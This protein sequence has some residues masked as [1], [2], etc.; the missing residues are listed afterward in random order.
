MSRGALPA[1]A[2]VVVVGGGVMGTSAA[3][4]LAEAGAEVVLLERDALASG[5]TS[6][7][8]GGVR[9]QFSDPLNIA[10]ALRSIDSFE[11]FAER[12]GAE[13]DLKQV[14]YLFLLDRAEDVAAFEAAVALQNELGVPSRMVSA[15]EAGALSPLAGIEGVLAATFC[16][17]DGHASPEAVVS[18]YA[19]GAR[20]RGA[21]IVTGCAVSDIEV[22]GGRISRV[23]TALGD[24]ETE[25][26]ACCAGAWSRSV[27]AMIGVDLPVQP[28]LRQIHYTAPVDDLP[29]AIPLTID[30]STGF[31]FHREGPGLLFGMADR[32][33]PPGFDRSADPDWL[34][35]VLEVAERRC[36]RL[37]DLGLAG[38]WKGFY[39][40][41]PDHNALVG[42]A[43]SPSRFLYATGLL[44]AR[45]PA[46]ARDRR[47][48]PR[49]R[50]APGAVRRRRAAVGRSL[51]RRPRAPRAQ[52]DLRHSD[53]LVSD[54]APRCQTPILRRRISLPSQPCCA[55]PPRTSRPARCWGRTRRPGSRRR[56]AACGRAARSRRHLPRRSPRARR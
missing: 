37:P 35:P 23:R 45:V 53:V 19:A 14:G 21:T 25:V 28:V 46:G 30:F 22:D 18:G 43:E 39:E 54:T 48:R 49:P 36:P 34:L 10:I 27:G 56:V 8:A 55:R 42:E 52:R 44:R 24:V 9:T 2:D 5:S 31:Y 26:V 11:R 29:E 47:D 13:I 7:A 3:F 33:Q 50:A 4:H 38:G 12:P 1:R 15:E 32:E 17:L 20:A 6:K 16:P 40:V 51:R 41:S